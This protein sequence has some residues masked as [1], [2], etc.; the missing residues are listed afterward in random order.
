MPKTIDA[1]ALRNFDVETFLKSRIKKCSL[2]A[3]CL[4]NL[5]AADY[6]DFDALQCKRKSYSQLAAE[7]KNFREKLIRHH[8]RLLSLGLKLTANVAK[9]DSDEVY[10]KI[11]K[12][13]SKRGFVLS[14]RYTEIA[15]RLEKAE[16]ICAEMIMKIEQCQKACISKVIASRL[17]EARKAAKMTQAELASR[18]GLKRI[19][20]AAYE[21]SQNVPN[22]VMLLA[23]SR[24]LN[25]P[26]NFFFE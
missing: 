21:V 22:A 18:L 6:D 4:T 19:R 8:N 2:K 10:L 3:D 12:P 17:K 5:D 26:V 11:Y 7:C 15:Q 9:L 16:S 14:G 25:R 13:K 1:F 23:L 20:Y 24:E